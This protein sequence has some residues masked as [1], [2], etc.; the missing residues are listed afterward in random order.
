MKSN[1]KLFLQKVKLLN[2]GS[3]IVAYPTFFHI[4]LFVL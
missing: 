4:L 3:S 2:L 1:A